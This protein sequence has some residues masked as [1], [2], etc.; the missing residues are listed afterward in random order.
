MK[1]QWQRPSAKFCDSAAC[2][3]VCDTAARVELSWKKPCESAHCVETAQGGAGVL[4]R[5]SGAPET[6]VEL[7]REEFSA[8][9]NAIKGGEYDGYVL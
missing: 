3:E 2:V 8:F 9:V 7:T 1:Q 6:M 5:A 4:L